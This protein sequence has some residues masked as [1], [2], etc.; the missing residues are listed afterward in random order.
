LNVIEV[1]YRHG[2]G[3]ADIKAPMFITQST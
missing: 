1:N 2:A 3:H